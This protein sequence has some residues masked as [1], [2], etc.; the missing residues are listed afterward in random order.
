LNWATRRTP[1]GEFTV[2]TDDDGAVYASGW[3][4]DPQRLLRLMAPELR[5][6][7]L[8]KRRDLGVATA[9]L[10]DY[11]AGDVR[12][13]DAVPVVQSGSPFRQR[14]WSELRRIAPGDPL[15]Y[16]ELAAACGNPSASRAA[17]TACGTNAAALFVPCHRVVRSGG[18]L[19]GFGWGL[20]VKR[21]LLDHE[22]APA[23]SSERARV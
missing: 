8:R 13:I 3:T 17:G 23:G 1:G 18:G 21:W 9:A 19:G 15:S 4:G 6:I 12:A 5:P 11:L 2:L 14:A 20:E 7:E 10:K 16:A 22:S